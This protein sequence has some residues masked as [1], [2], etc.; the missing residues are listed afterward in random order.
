MFVDRVEIE[1]QAGRGGDGC[2]SFR[3]EKWVPR[4]GPDG[5]DGGHGASLILEAKLGVN[6]LA[7]FANRRFYRAKKGM[8]GE[9]ALRHGR[10][11]KDE[12][13]YVPPGTAVIDAQHGYI[14]KDLS[15]PGDKFVVARGGKGGHGNARFKSSTNQAPRER[16]L[17][18]EGESRKVILELKSIAD[19]G[20]VGK[21]NAG[22]STL[23]SRIS[24]ARPEIADYPFTTKHPNLGIVILN[25]DQSF[26]MAD[27]PGLIEGASE[28]V[29][30][31]HEF[32]KH[33]ERAGLLVHLVEPEPVD[34][35]EPLENYQAIRGELQHYDQSLGEREELLVVTKCEFESADDVANSLRETTG[36]DVLLISAQTGDGLT[37][38][39]REIMRRVDLRRASLRAAGESPVL[40]RPDDLRQREDEDAVRRRNTPPH[41]AGPTSMLGG[42]LHAQ[43]VDDDM[44]E[45]HAAQHQ[46][47]SE[48]GNGDD[49]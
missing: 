30:L 6:S 34:G 1:L 47:E 24:S 33:V 46:Q 35:T 12:T 29:G 3:R 48:S 21:P 13:L 18:E 28:G 42:E 39:K 8:P 36:N 2:M 19:V 20:L 4:G 32:L 31:G 10:Q 49:D 7:A 16:K 11:G 23:L 9:G 15:H 27:I 40:L 22:K 45:K 37:E 25:E 43:H 38:L 17:G 26:V 44:A 14:I 41:L 5:G